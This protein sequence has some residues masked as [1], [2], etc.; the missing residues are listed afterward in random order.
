MTGLTTYRKKRDFKK[1]REPSGKKNKTTQFRFVVQRHQASHL[2]YDFRLELGGV[3]KSWAVPKGPSLNP[4]QK[5]LA[6]MVEDHP[7]DYISFK[8]RIPEGNYGAGTVEIWDHGTFIPVNAKEEPIS[9]QMALQAI[10]KGEIKFQLKGKK[11]KGGFVLVKLKNDEKNWLLIKHKDEYAVNKIYDA[12]ETLNGTSQKTNGTSQKTITSIRFGKGKKLHDFIKP[13]LAS[14]SKTAFDDKDWLY[15]IKW[16]GYRAIAA[17]KNG[18]L[19]LYSRNGIDFKTRF[20]SIAQALL[21]IKH[22]VVLDGEI[23]LL[24]E[25][26]LP[27]FQKLQHYENH[28]N[29]PLIYYV[30]DMLSLDGKDTKQL[31]L[32]D[33]KKL[34]KKLLGKNKTVQYCDHIENNGIAFLDKAKEQGLEGIIAKKKDSS[35]TPGIRSKEWLKLKNV[36]STE[37]VIVGY[38]EPQGGRTHFGSLILAS[39]KAKKWQYRGHVGTGFSHEKLGSLKKMM[40]P[41]QTDESPFQ[42]KVPLNGKTTWLKPKLV[43][44]IAYTEMTRDGIFRHPSFLRLRDEKTT[45]TINDESLED[46]KE[47]KRNEEVKVGKET[48]AITNRHKIFWPDEGYTKGDVID[49]YDKMSSFILPHLKDR[50]LSLKRNPNGIR[51]EGF[52]H[53]DAGE[54]APAFV[55][56]FPVKSESSNKTIDYIV[57]NNKATLLYLANLGCI[58]MNPWNSTTQYPGKPSWLVID[59]DPSAKNSFEEVVDVA[60][61]TKQVFDK[62]GITC[63]C[64]TSGAS[65]LHVYAPMKNKYDYATIRDFAHIIAAMVQEQLPDTT[66][67]ERSL[68]KRGPKIY[69]DYLQN[70]GGQTLASVYS[71]RPKP[72]ATVSTPL[73]WKEVTH[74][75]HPSQFTIQNILERVKKKGD[76]FKKVITSSNNIKTALKKLN[77]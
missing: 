25:K 70:S 7:V 65:G 32:T 20:P 69:V 60:L 23:V 38:T 33:R 37:A 53:K 73:D 43:A 22:D 35:Y 75:L 48:V 31:P 10:Q 36:Q 74:K 63:F 67:I 47:V 4:S 45:E 58:E 56:V 13:M 28:L 34:V 76:L 26:D 19:D 66:S 71:L 55:K 5:R 16:D 40:K 1:T 6:V 29:Y 9:E 49:Y 62:A 11:L 68:K 50:P 61:M 14:I 52:Y 24:N 17:L 44:D 15:E 18:N 42:E 64:K 3:L 41:L 46:M 59:I 57:C 8:G 2:H 54:N 39:P 30:F 77:K 51:D 21:K 27:D 12:E 72:G